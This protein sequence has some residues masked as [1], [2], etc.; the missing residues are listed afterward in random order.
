MN[1]A[2]VDKG[3][4]AGRIRNC[5]YD[6]RRGEMSE[7]GVRDWGLGAR[8]GMKLEVREQNAEFRASRRERR[9]E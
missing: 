1:A 4:G 2:P 6:E 9:E 5:A 8:D 3:E 7:I